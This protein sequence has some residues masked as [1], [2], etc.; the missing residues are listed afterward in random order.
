M[1]DT[2]LYGN[3]DFSLIIGATVAPTD[4]TDY[5][6]VANMFGQLKKLK[7]S[8]KIEYA[9]HFKSQNG[10]KV[11]DANRPKQ[12]ELNYTATCEYFDAKVLRAMFYATQLADQAAAGGVPAYEIFT[13]LAAPKGLRGFARLRF[14]DTEDSAHPK[15]VHE[16]FE[17]TVRMTSEP[18]MGDD[19]ASVELLIEVLATV[20][21]VKLQKAA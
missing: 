9:P 2:L 16:D 14:W 20:G 15:L 11:K 19:Y 5:D 12:A 7:I 6:E 13:P 21:K 10:L 1:A 17:C 18:E 3:G 8:P 4:K